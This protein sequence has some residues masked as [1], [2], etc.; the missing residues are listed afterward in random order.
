MTVEFA[1]WHIPHRME[2][3]GYE[4]FITRWRHLQID[5]KASLEIQASNE[6]YYLI[7]P[8]KEIKVRSRKGVF[9]LDDK[10]IDEMK[11]EHSGKIEIKNSDNKSQMVLFIV[12][13]PDHKK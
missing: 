11:Y 12:A 13:I 1:I 2:E 6:Y 3:M 8:V 5:K 7:S 10:A 9:D 4:K